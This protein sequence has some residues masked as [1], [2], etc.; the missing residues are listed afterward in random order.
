MLNWRPELLWKDS[1]QWI[2]GAVHWLES[3]RCCFQVRSTISGV[4]WSFSV[5]EG[6]RFR[7]DQTAKSADAQHSDQWNCGHR[8]LLSL[9]RL[10]YLKMSATGQSWVPG[11]YNTTGMWPF[12]FVRQNDEAGRKKEIPAVSWVRWN[13]LHSHLFLWSP[14]LSIK[15][16]LTVGSCTAAST[17]ITYAREK[18][19]FAVLVIMNSF[20][21]EFCAPEKE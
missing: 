4:Q 16:Q 12:V 1:W 6:I 8:I 14:K 2:A 11:T 3:V 10:S 21:D 5:V 18:Y 13:T 19:L 9:Q 7:R 15:R 17:K 20:C